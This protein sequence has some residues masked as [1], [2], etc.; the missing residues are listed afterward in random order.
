ML[1]NSCPF[2]LH[3]RP[4]EVEG[5]SHCTEAV[6]ASLAD[7]RA[8]HPQV[9]ITSTWKGSYAGEVPKAAA[10]YAAMWRRLEADGMRVIALGDTPAPGKD[11]TVADCASGSDPAAC[12]RS[13]QRATATPDP[14]RRAAA[15]AGVPFIDPVDAFC[16]ATR[17]PGV[18]GNVLVY[19]D[20]NHVTDAYMQTM[21]PWIEQRVGALVERELAAR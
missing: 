14:L 7:L 5:G 1:H 10:G 20:D 21:T 2:S 4:L 15:S 9:V 18:I 8:E 17:C 11:P 16:G 6:R 19:R 13:R 12:G 3:P